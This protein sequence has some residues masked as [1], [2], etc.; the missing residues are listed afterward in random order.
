MPGRERRHEIQHALQTIL[1]AHKLHGEVLVRLVHEAEGNVAQQQ[2][3]FKEKDN[4]SVV[5]SAGRHHKELLH[6][7]C[8]VIEENG[9]DVAHADLSQTT[10]GFDKNVFWIRHKNGSALNDSERGDLKAIIQNVYI[11]HTDAVG[12]SVEIESNS[13]HTSPV[14]SLVLDA[15]SAQS[16][17][18]DPL[19]RAK[20]LINSPSPAVSWA[21]PSRGR[22]PR[23]SKELMV[24][25]GTPYSAQHAMLRKAERA[26]ERAARLSREFMAERE[27][28]AAS[29]T[30]AT[31]I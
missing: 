5:S 3:R 7:I 26:A 22:S 11:R 16:V 9:Y 2:P 19:E 18:D 13:P 1:K 10:N 4:V 6:A 31:R 25:D 21:S 8:D 27:D 23:S 30:S 15:V 17:S 29:S 14:S 28:R 20:A 24:D 12:L